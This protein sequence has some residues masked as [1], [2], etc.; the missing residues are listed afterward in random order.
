MV[1]NSK[2]PDDKV[3]RRKMLGL[4]G[5]FACATTFSACSSTFETKSDKNQL[6]VYSWADYLHPDVIPEFEKETGIR[7]VYDTF[8][9]NE[10]L[11][12]KLQA[13]ASDYDI[14]VPTGYMLRQLVKMKLLSGI[15]HERLRNIGN[16]MEHFRNPAY[17]RGLSYSVPYTWGTTGIAYNAQAIEGVLV[18]QAFEEQI[19]YVSGARTPADW[20]VFWDRRLKQRITLLDDARETIGLALKRRGYSY[21]TRDEAAIRAAI[22][23]LTEQKP[24][25]MCYTSDQVITQLASGDSWLSLVYSGD[26]Y[27]A[28]KENEYLKYVIPL[29]GT[30]IWTD[31]LC[32]PKLAPHPE[33]AYKWIDFIL[34]PEIGASIA[35][36]TRYATPNQKAVPLVS[37]ELRQD[38]NLY[39]SEQVMMRCEEIGDVGPAIRLY[40][41]MW[42]EL[43]CS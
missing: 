14:V 7:V 19:L 8:A 36:F 1:D 38:R 39:L 24:L 15:D 10:A 13:G 27:Q 28:R 34:R 21:N 26:A 37:E 12:A 18:R 32:I 17:D 5:A 30:S 43:K 42:T 35:N 4:L 41:Q 22:V 2:P 23:D 16:I 31:N 11:L 9:S 33:N 20:D 40:D 29:S 6:N 25:T 3:S